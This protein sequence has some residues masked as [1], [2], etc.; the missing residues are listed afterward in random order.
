MTSL[1]PHG[2]MAQGVC[3]YSAPSSS[4]C[5]P[6]RSSSWWSPAPST[7]CRASDRSTSSPAAARNIRPPPWST[8]STS[9]PSLTATPTSDTPPHKR[10]CCCSSS[11]SSPRSNSESW[12][13]RCSTDDRLG[14]HHHEDP[15][16]PAAKE[17]GQHHRWPHRHLPRAGAVPGTDRI[18]RLLR[19]HRIRHGPRG[20]QLLPGLP[21]AVGRVRLVELSRCAV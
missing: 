14:T 9:K 3:D 15:A 10:W 7:P 5:S 13:G 6:R 11:S 1:R 19:L 20:H 18:P 8:R 17:G 4:P 21:V 16:D 12:R 2:W